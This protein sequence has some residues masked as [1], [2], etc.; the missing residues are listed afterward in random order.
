M[1]TQF[2]EIVV[3]RHRAVLSLG[4]ALLVALSA[5]VLAAEPA[6]KLS[7]VTDRPEA[8]YAVGQQAN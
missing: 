8:I 4:W 7:V 3:M 5:S 1:G 6:Y 2:Q